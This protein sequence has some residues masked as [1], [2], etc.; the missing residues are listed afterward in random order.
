MSVV[1]VLYT[2]PLANT[3]RVTQLTVGTSIASSLY[4]LVLIYQTTGNQQAMNEMEKLGYDKQAMKAWLSD[5]RSES[6]IRLRHYTTERAKR[7][8]SITGVINS[9][10][11]AGNYFTPDQY[12]SGEEATDRLATKDEREFYIELNLYKKADLLEGPEKIPPHTYITEDDIRI[13]QGGGIQ[14]YTYKPIWTGGLM[15]ASSNWIPLSE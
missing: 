11:G 7:A 2:T 1:D 12:T 6:P 5:A 3:I 8:I 15:R 13:R 4:G 9:P 10:T 14:Y